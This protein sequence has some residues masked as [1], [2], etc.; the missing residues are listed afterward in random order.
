MKKFEYLEDIAVADIAFDAFGK[1]LNELFTNAAL[2]LFNMQVDLKTVTSKKT[3]KVKLKNEKIDN[4]L[5]DFL[6]EIIFLKDKDYSIFD[7]VKVKITEKNKT[8]HLEAEIKGEKINP[9]KHKLGND[10]KAVT[11]HLFEVK[12]LKKYWKARVIVD[13]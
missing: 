10:V 6:D 12:K 8:Y 11:L 1:D 13:I 5:F 9:K 7:K 4:L 2:A 3:W